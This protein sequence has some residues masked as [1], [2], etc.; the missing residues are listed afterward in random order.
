MTV[1][2]VAQSYIPIVYYC[3]LIAVAHTC[4][5]QGAQDNRGE[6]HKQQSKPSGLSVLPIYKHMPPC[7]Q[8]YA[9]RKGYSVAGG[10]GYQKSQRTCCTELTSRAGARRKVQS[11]CMA[12]P[13]C[14][15]LV[16]LRKVYRVKLVIIMV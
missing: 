13:P 7:N 16:S 10:R 8:Q 12:R 4:S 5:G 2:T 11:A 1:T 3:L 9:I 14:R 6:S 15:N